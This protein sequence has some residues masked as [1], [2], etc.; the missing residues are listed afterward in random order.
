MQ[1]GAEGKRFRPTMLLLMASSLSSVM[2]SP[3]YLT[4]DDRPP[5]VHPEE[6]SRSCPAKHVTVALHSGNPSMIFAC[7][8][9]LEQLHCLA[10][11]AELH[12][13]INKQS[14]TGFNVSTMA[15]ERRRQQRIAEIT[16][17]IHVASLL[18]DDVIDNAGDMHAAVS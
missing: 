11:R 3:D 5:N 9:V 2:P 13:H 15:Q 17:M 4:V 8:V 18:H 12:Y 10:C 16:E 14:L 6:V 1:V 7:W